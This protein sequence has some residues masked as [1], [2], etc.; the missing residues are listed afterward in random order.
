[1]RKLLANRAVYVNWLHDALVEAKIK[2]VIPPNLTAASL[3]SSTERST[4][5]GICHSES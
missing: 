3:P 4:R 2:A 1:M 5:G